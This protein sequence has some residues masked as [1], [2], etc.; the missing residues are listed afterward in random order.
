MYRELLGELGPTGSEFRAGRGP[1]LPLSAPSTNQSHPEELSKRSTC[2]KKKTGKKVDRDCSAPLLAW[3]GIPSGPPHLVQDVAVLGKDV[4]QEGHARD[5]EA[6]D[7]LSARFVCENRKQK[8]ST[9]NK[10]QKTKIIIIRSKISIIFPSVRFACE[11]RKTKNIKHKTK[12]N[13]KKH[14]PQ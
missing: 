12:H 2:R 3:V 6:P 4:L 8:H 10:T 11:K 9:K 1:P 7:Y 13:N 5:L 14:H